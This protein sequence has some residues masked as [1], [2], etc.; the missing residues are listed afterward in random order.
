[1]WLKWRKFQENSF[2][3]WT[4]LLLSWFHPQLVDNGKKKVN[5][6]YKWS[7][8]TTTVTFFCGSAVG[9]S[10]PLQLIYKASQLAVILGILFRTTGIYMQYELCLW[11]YKFTICSINWQASETFSGLFNRESRYMCVIVRMSLFPFDL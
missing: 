3:I 2:S 1:M 10:L 11:N 7:L 9:D 6:E 8:L 5:V 4:R